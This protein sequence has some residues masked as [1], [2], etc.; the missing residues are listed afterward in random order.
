MRGDVVVL[1]EAQQ[2]LFR[3]LQVHVQ[4]NISEHFLWWMYG[5]PL[6]VA[7][8]WNESVMYEKVVI[9]ST[10]GSS[11]VGC[12]EAVSGLDRSFPLVRRICK[13]IMFCQ[14]EPIRTFTALIGSSSLYTW[15][16]MDIEFLMVCFAGLKQ[17]RD[18]LGIL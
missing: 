10:G 7:I 14:W 11:V 1:G 4:S 6:S 8:D 17:A 18:N 5:G 16:I 13:R 15:E 12:V 3:E 9:V 2:L